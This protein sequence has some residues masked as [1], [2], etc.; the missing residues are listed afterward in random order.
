MDSDVLVRPAHPADVAGIQDVADA[1]WHAVYD[2]IIGADAVEEMLGEWYE[3]DAIEAGIGHDA[4][5]FFVAVRDET[6]VGYAHVGPHPPQRTHRLYRLYVHPD[7][8]R[9]GIGQALLAD[10]E[11]SLY[12][13]DV[14]YYEAEVLADNDVAV[15]FYE[16][17]GFELVEEDE[18]ELAGVTAEQRI[19]RKRL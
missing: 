15:S 7:E 19:Y 8:W 9:G 13:R 14:H 17:S 11:Q 1:A 12:D 5:D 6:V 3:D 4:Q 18:T 2:D 16:S 10:I